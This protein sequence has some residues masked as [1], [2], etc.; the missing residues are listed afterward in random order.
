MPSDTNTRDVTD[1]LDQREESRPLAVGTHHAM[2]EKEPNLWGIDP[3]GIPGIYCG[4]K[5]NTLIEVWGWE[6][7]GKRFYSLAEVNC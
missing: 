6:E 2:V 3:V 7:G 5:W 1:I 4:A